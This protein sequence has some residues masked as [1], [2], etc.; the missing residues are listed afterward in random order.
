MLSVLLIL[1]AKIVWIILIE[2][3]TVH[4]F[5]DTMRLELGVKNATCN[6]KNVKIRL[7]IVQFVIQGIKDL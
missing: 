6:A 4:V 1:F 5:Q 2:M 7:I 3:L